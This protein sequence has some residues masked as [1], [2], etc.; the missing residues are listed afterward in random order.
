MKTAAQLALRALALLLMA[1]GTAAAGSGCPD[2]AVAAAA[3][4]TVAEV[5]AGDTVRL[6]DGRI[7]RLAGIEAPRLPLGAPPGTPWPLAD[8]AKSVLESLLAGATV[9]VLAPPGAEVD[10]YGRP[11]A[12]LRLADGRDVAMALV[13]AGLARV[14]WGP[15]EAGCAPKLL[16]TEGPARAA[17]RGLWALPD[18]AVRAAGDSS[19]A[20]EIGLY[21]LVEGRPTSV[22]QGI[23]MTFIDFGHIYWRDFTIMVPD[24]VAKALVD[25]GTPVRDMVGRRIR[26]RG[27]IE[28]AGG[29]AI[30]LWDPLQIEFVG[31]GNGDAGASADR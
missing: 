1:S 16:A 9:T 11:H 10:R 20:G 30:R 31:A 22:G 17:K 14:R 26:V 28:A 29:P 6:G 3:P 15:G 19:L 5:V 18:Y 8:A 12:S 4:V 2:G 7:V 24:S 27:V 21:E 13:G 25:A 23:R